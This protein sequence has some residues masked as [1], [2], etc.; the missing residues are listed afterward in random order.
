ME[1]EI[2]SGGK[3]VVR[4]CCMNFFNK[5]KE[6]TNKNYRHGNNISK[7]FQLEMCII[8]MIAIYTPFYLDRLLG[9]MVLSTQNQASV[10]ETGILLTQL[11]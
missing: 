8:G 10:W 9:Y 2:V 11:L 3:T 7:Q 1:L 5:G 6:I 4:I